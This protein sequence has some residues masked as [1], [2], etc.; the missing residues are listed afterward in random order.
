M[1][2]LQRSFHP[3][4]EW[5][6]YKIYTGP[7]TADLLLTELVNPIAESLISDNIIDKWF[8][9]RYQDP[10]FHLRVRF[11]TSDLTNVGK[12]MIRFTSKAHSYIKEGLIWKLQLD[13]YDREVE[14]YGLKTMEVSETLFFHDS[15]MI[16]NLLNLIDDS[17]EGEKLRWLFSLKA[18]D[19]FLDDFSLSEDHKLYIIEQM[20][21]SFCSEFNMNKHLKKQLDKK[22]IA[23][24]TDIDDFMTTTINNAGELLPI[25]HLLDTKSKS[26]KLLAKDIISSADKNNLDHFFTS[27]IHMIMNR[28]FRSNNRLFEMVIYYFLFKNYKAAIG[29]KK[30]MLKREVA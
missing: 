12:I 2:N 29:K 23:Y 16:T 27:H 25:Y 1:T 24:R 21:I 15:T 3:G 19:T 8:Y 18:I 9:I 14:R 20:K 10:K 28:I 13:T 7:K 11:K 17:D 5:V 6:Y 30:H 22:F 4:E 26:S